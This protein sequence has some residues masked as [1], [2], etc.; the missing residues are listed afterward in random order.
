MTGARARVFSID[1]VASSPPA[2]LMR[3][4]RSPWSK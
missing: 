1:A 2:M 3:K 4:K